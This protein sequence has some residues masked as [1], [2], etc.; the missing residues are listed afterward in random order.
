MVY[1][2]L[3]GAKMN[4]KSG[5]SKDAGADAQHLAQMRRR[6]ALTILFDK[7]ESHSF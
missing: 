6:K 2:S 7:L 1:R 3:Y 5:T 4:K